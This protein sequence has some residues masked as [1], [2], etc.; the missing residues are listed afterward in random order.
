MTMRRVTSVDHYHVALEH[1]AGFFC[2][3]KPVVR[4][5]LHWTRRRFVSAILDGRITVADIDSSDTTAS[6]AAPHKGG[7]GR[8]GRRIVTQ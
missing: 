4:P 3:G 2:N 8:T 6:L 1:G 7:Y 5:D